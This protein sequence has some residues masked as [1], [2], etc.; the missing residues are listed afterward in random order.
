[1]SFILFLF[2]NKV[3]TSEKF[4]Y[5]IIIIFLKHKRIY[6]E[7]RRIGIYIDI[8]LLILFL[9]IFFLSISIPG[10][11]ERIRLNNKN[12]P[13][14][15]YYKNVFGR[16]LEPKFFSPAKLEK[17]Y[18]FMEFKNSK[19]ALDELNGIIINDGKLPYFGFNGKFWVWFTQNNEK[20]RV[21]FVLKDN[22]LTTIVTRVLENDKF[23]IIKYLSKSVNV[24]S[25]SICIKSMRGLE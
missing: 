21:F 19:V 13:E 20:Y 10:S 16:L 22:K 1:M 5:F 9:M 24:K 23:Q 6:D 2:L 12:E 15:L 7:L 18:D 14:F 25:A 8:A 4:F 17:S 11:F 3:D